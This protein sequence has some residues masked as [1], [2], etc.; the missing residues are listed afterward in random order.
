MK[1]YIINTIKDMGFEYNMTAKQLADRVVS[2]HTVVWEYS[3]NVNLN[4]DYSAI[5]WEEIESL[6][7]K[8]EDLK[9]RRLI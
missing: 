6:P 2:G 5:N 7:F 8:F 4:G 3:G 1:Q 9:Q